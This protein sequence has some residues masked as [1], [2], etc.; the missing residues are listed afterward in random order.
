MKIYDISQELLTSRVYEGDPR[1]KAEKI[2]SIENGDR[3]NLTTLSLCAHNGTHIDAPSHF[4]REGAS[5]ES[6]P[7]YKTVGYAAVVAAEGNITI[8]EAERI[9]AIAKNFGNEAE[10]RIL[11]KGSATL[12]ERAAEYLAERGI[13]L[14]ATESQSVGPESAPMA[15]HKILLEK[16]V[17]LLEGVRLT[18][19]AEGCYFLFSAPISVSGADGAPCR[20][21]LIE[22]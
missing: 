19:V 11:I 1:P 10:K 14:I 18:D 22:F 21:I 7:L 9:L 12:T 15:V 5:V 2:R 17:V 16:E 3:Y 8:T 4:L 20:A 6:I 13:Y